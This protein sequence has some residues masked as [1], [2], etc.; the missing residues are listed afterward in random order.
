MNEKIIRTVRF[1]YIK[2][3]YHLIEMSSHLKE[4]AY[5]WQGKSIVNAS[6]IMGVF[7]ID[8]SENFKIHYDYDPE[9]DKFIS[10]FEVK[11]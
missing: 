10:L 8:P 6:S 9:F 7:S 11:D 3:I 4:P 2:D 1:N 5:I